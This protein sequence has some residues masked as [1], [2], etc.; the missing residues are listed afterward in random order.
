MPKL[1]AAA[2]ASLSWVMD[3]FFFVDLFVNFRVGFMDD[4]ELIVDAH[5]IATKYLSSWFVVD[6]FST[7]SSVIQVIH[8]QS[9]CTVLA[10]NLLAS[11]P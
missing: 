7:A 2:R 9:K 8:T 11:P 10:Y 4:G 3:I 6:F 1:H 5:T